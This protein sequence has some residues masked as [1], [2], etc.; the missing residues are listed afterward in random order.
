M[1]Q[2]CSDWRPARRML[3]EELLDRQ[4]LTPRPGLLVGWPC[5]LCGAPISHQRRGFAA[6]TGQQECAAARLF[7]QQRAENRNSL[8]KLLRAVRAKTE[9]EEPVALRLRKE[10]PSRRD[11]DAALQRRQ[12]EIALTNTLRQR[13]P[14]IQAAGWP[15]PLPPVAESVERDQRRVAS[16]AVARADTGEM[17]IEPALAKVAG[18]RPLEQ[19]RADKVYAVLGRGQ[20]SKLFR[21]SDKRTQAQPWHQHFGEAHAVYDTPVRVARL[22]SRWRRGIIAKLP[23]HIV[24]EDEEPARAGAFQ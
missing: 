6:G 5:R 3:S 12:A 16:L 9:T 1:C 4:R 11:A 18:E 23:V 10:G 8:G 2:K 7:A 19:R 14:H 24:F 22:E 20:R 17:R 13:H 21:F 15:R